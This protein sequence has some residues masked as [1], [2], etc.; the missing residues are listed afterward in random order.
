MANLARLG[1]E[2]GEVD[3]AAGAL[4]GDIQNEPINRSGLPARDHAAVG[5]EDVYIVNTFS[6]DRERWQIWFTLNDTG[7]YEFDHA[8][9]YQA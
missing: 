9:R 4:V 7:R 1:F 6:P 8:A 5:P 2:V 3:G